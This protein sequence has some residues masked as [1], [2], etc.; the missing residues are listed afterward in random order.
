MIAMS[1]A[2]RSIDSS[3]TAMGYNAVQQKGATNF[4][5]QNFPL[6][7]EMGARTFTIP[8]YLSECTEHPQF[9]Q[10]LLWVV[11]KKSPISFSS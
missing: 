1:G 10:A 11:R 6:F 4:N 2:T 8:A 9:A 7:I 5:K 3:S